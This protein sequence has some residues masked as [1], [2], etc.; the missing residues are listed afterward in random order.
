MHEKHGQ[1]DFN[2]LAPDLYISDLHPLCI[3]LQRG[4]T[5]RPRDKGDLSHTFYNLRFNGEVAT[6]SRCYMRRLRSVRLDTY[7]AV[8]LKCLPIIWR[9]DGANTRSAA[10]T[11]AVLV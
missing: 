10:S 9:L 8:W 7:D 4:V 5:R 3:L 6:I 11:V 1:M 2:I